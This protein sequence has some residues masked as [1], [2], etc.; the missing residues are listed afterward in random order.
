MENK[1]KSLLFEQMPIPKA[2]FTLAVPT[3]LSSLVM[4]LYNLADTWFVGMLNDPIQ[5]AAVTLASPVLLAFNAVNNLFGVGTSS[6][7]S[8]QERRRNRTPQFGIW[9][10]GI[11]LQ[12]P[13]LFPAVYS[14]PHTA[15]F[16]VR[17]LCR[18][19]RSYR[20][21]LILDCNVWSGTVHSERCACLSCPHRGRF[22]A[23]QHRHYERL[24]AQ[25]RAGPDFYPSVGAQYGGC[26]R[27]TCYL[28]FQLFCLPVFLCAVIY[29]KE[30]HVCLPSPKNGCS[31]TRYCIWHLCRWHSCFN[32]KS[33]KRNRNDCNEQFCLCLRLGRSRCHRHCLQNQYDSDAGGYGIFAGH[34]AAYQL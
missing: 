34:H 30:I 24:P 15:S 3:I 6:T 10:L 27:G 1:Q 33:F 18:K 12:R 29:K 11:C 17:C 14:I 5:N 4:V 7:S 19:L 21:L 26:R 16:C 23:R 2:V 13:A 22:H 20:G 31:K 9:V 25:Y 8:G 28:Y 32:S